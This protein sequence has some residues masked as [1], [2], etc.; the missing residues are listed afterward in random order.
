MDIELALT[1]E[2]REVFWDCLAQSSGIDFLDLVYAQEM[3]AQKDNILHSWYNGK[4][5]PD[6]SMHQIWTHESEME[7]IQ[8]VADFVSRIFQAKL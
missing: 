1:Y 2:G 6:I 3:D 5:R 4:E 8:N 7:F